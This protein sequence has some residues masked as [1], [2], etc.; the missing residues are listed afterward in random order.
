MALVCDYRIISQ[1]ALFII[2]SRMY[3]VFGPDM[4]LEL[5]PEQYIQLQ[6]FNRDLDAWKMTF[7]NRLRM[8]GQIPCNKCTC[9]LLGFSYNQIEI[10]TAILHDL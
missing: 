8:F 2:L 9:S 7:Q 3:D 6:G 5:Q 1:V 10:L 4:D